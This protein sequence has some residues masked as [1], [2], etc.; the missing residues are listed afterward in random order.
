MKFIS[1]DEYQPTV[2][3][4]AFDAPLHENLEK[5][6]RPG[7]PFH[8]NQHTGGIGGGLEYVTQP[9]RLQQYS[10]AQQRAMVEDFER[11][12]GMTMEQ[13]VNRAFGHLMHAPEEA[14]QHAGWYRKVHDEC[15]AIGK[16]L[17]VSTSMVVAT[18]AAV[19]PQ[20]AWD[21]A[22]PKSKPRK[23][24][25]P[26]SDARPNMQ[27]AI[28][29]LKAWKLYTEP[30]KDGTVPK[31]KITKTL[32]KNKKLSVK[33]PGE[34]DLREL[35]VSDQAKVI[36]PFAGKLGGTDYMTDDMVKNALNILATG[37]IDGNLG[38]SKVRSFFNDIMSGGTATATTIDT[39]MARGLSN[40]PKE[41][42][43]HLL[44]DLGLAAPKDGTRTVA[45]DPDTGEQYNPR[46]RK[47]QSQFQKYPLNR[48]GKPAST[49]GLGTYPVFEEILHQVTRKY[50]EQVA[51]TA[52]PLGVFRGKALYPADVQ[53]VLWYV[54]RWGLDAS[55][56]DA[57]A[58]SDAATARLGIAKGDR[59][60]HKFHG[61]QYVKVGPRG[62]RS[63][64]I[65]TREA[66][67]LPK[68][69]YDSI[70]DEKQGHGIT[71]K[72]GSGFRPRTGFIVSIPGHEEIIGQYEDL[73]P[74]VIKKYLRTHK[75]EL[76]HDRHYLGG[77]KSG[78]KVYLDVSRRFRNMGEAIRFGLEGNQIAITWM[79]GKG[80]MDWIYLT[81][82]ESKEWSKE[83]AAAKSGLMK[84]DE[85]PIRFYLNHHDSPERILSEIRRLCEG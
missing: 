54:Y 70:R 72:V 35:S 53:A 84:S 13:A 57:A 41:P 21:F 1:P 5:G 37:S 26:P 47:W 15:E 17:G 63:A 38:G 29:V 83:I 71:I 8:G 16:S 44:N 10:A 12:S 73:T 19:S 39:Y 55:A 49:Q 58:A 77:W 33:Q 7:H 69:A 82:P 67:N 62:G 61:N 51:Q 48:E 40:L 43:E 34:Y 78:D 68:T 45:I 65:A 85:Q 18:V 74:A 64:G 2:I 80:E 76:S 42:A 81:G 20:T 22:R 32:I 9:G 59:A 31:V 66:R 11:E 23:D 75:K 50:N 36:K 46:G 25:K 27:V 60:G 6:D 24:G 28:G 52:S 30:G 14:R 56:P 4:R 79:K 3:S